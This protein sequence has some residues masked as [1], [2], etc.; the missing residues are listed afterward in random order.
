MILKQFW[1]EVTKD[2]VLKIVGVGRFYFYTWKTE[3]ATR[4]RQRKI[5]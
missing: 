5:V 4:V 3:R 1:K 2:V